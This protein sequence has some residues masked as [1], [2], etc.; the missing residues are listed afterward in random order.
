MTDDSPTND[1]EIAE[2]T[3]R[4][5]ARSDE[6]SRQPAI[7]VI[8]LVDT[9]GAGGRPGEEENDPW[10]LTFL[11]HRW[12][13]P[14]GPMNTRPLT[15]S[16]TAPRPD[17]RSLKKQI[18]PYHVLAIRARVVE[19]SVLGSPQA[20]LVE[21]LGPD[22]SDSEMI[23]AAVDLKT[24]VTENDPLFGLFTLDRQTNR[25]TAKVKWNGKIVLLN[26]HADHSSK[27]DGAA[28]QVA[29]ALW[30]D[31]K[32]WTKRIQDYAVQELLPIWDNAWRDD[33]EAELTPKKFQAK[34]G[35][36]S[37]SVDTD[38]SFEFWH[39]DGNLFLGHSILIGGNLT[40][41]PTQADIPG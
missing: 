6:L 7:Q 12:R 16:Y 24:P 9:S 23:Q 31:Q 39:N 29:K 2:L 32:S 4:L 10:T 27:L 17:Y 20:E 3:R 30:K 8:G 22:A 1:D 28:L 41:G 38:G 35:L 11:F 15:V 40:D 34:M 26:L 37:V 25:F 33:D 14:P 5:Q 21:F 36:E 13:I 18:G 19:E